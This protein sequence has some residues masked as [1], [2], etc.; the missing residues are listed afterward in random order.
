MTGKTPQ[1][2]EVNLTE[3]LEELSGIVSWFEQQERQ[4]LDVE[5][6]LQ[7]VR[8]AAVLIKASKGRL[9]QID[10][11]FKTIEK[12]IQTDID[13]PAVAAP[14]RAE[15]KTIEESPIEYPDEEVNPEDIPF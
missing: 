14:A 3:A 11:E 12:E 2:K 6:G 1:D 4:G 10:N 9:A 5:A 8:D 13:V 7:K 15:A